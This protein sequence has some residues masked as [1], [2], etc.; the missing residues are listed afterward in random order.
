VV[1]RELRLDPV[2]PGSHLGGPCLRQ[3]SF[4][5]HDQEVGALADREFVN[6][7]LQQLLLVVAAFNRG[8]VGLVRGL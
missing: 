1:E 4:V 6:L 2:R 3:V 8:G 7:R 5:L